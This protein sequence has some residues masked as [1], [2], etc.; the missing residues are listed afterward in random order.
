MILT[1]N[2]EKHEEYGYRHR[3]YIHDISATKIR[4]E[5]GLE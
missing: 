2:W 1:E 4:K 3:H 5:M